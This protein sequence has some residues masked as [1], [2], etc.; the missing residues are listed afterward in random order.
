MKKKKM[1]GQVEA[2]NICEFP[3][4]SNATEEKSNGFNSMPASKIKMFDQRRSMNNLNINVNALDHHHS[5]NER[6]S[7]NG[8]QQSYSREA[9]HVASPLGA[10]MSKIV[11][12]STGQNQNEA[13]AASVSPFEPNNKST[14]KT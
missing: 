4:S 5:S 12:V 10:D 1:L 13:V 3:R 14:Q 9:Q 6:Q 11:G 8:D 2:S 7:L